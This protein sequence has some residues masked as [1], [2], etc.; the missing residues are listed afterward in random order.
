MLP[1]VRSFDLDQVRCKQGA[2]L[3]GLPLD[4]SL[5]CRL[6]WN[7]DG[8]PTFVRQVSLVLGIWAK[9]DSQEELNVGHKYRWRL[10]L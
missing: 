2:K 5:L 4:S 6:A 3:D 7:V 10:Q 9:D 8:F 1:H